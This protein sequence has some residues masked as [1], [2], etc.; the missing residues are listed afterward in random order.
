MLGLLGGAL[1][2]GLAAAV[3]P[4]VRQ[5]ADIGVPRLETLTLDPWVLAYSLALALAIGI[6]FGVAPALSAARSQPAGALRRSGRGSV[7]RGRERVRSAL[8]I[9][10]VSLA[11]VVLVAAGLLLRSFDRLSRV[12]PGFAIERG[13]TFRVAPDWGTY[14]ER[15]Q[16]VTL[17]DEFLARVAAIPG[18]T[19]VAGVNRLPLTG[20]WWTTDYRQEGAVVERG[21]EQLAG[22][23]VVTPNYFSVMGISL[24]AGRGIEATD[25][26]NAR[27]AVVVSRSLAERAWPGASAIGRRVTF[28]PQ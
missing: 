15:S 6:A 8:I 23:R 14:R 1:G 16:A 9:A 24:L 11:A 2:A 7:S 20:G 17:Y 18:V 21:R 28:D 27:N 4:L 19:G 12:E 5:I 25:R 3:L 13:M 22:Y 10:Q 26:A